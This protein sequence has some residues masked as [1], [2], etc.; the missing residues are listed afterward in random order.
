MT[1]KPKKPESYVPLFP[2]DF[3]DRPKTPAEMGARHGADVFKQV[4]QA[5]TNWELAEEEMKTLFMVLSEVNSPSAWLAVKRAY[6]SIISNSSRRTAIESVAE[7]YCAEHWE[8]PVVKKP[9][10]DVIQNIGKASKRRDDVA[11]G[12]VVHHHQ[13]SSGVHTD[14]GAFLFPPDYN[15]ERTYAFLT[16]QPWYPGKDMWSESH[17]AKFRFTDKEI[18]EYA[19][20]FLTLKDAIWSLTTQLM[21]RD[22]VIPLIAAASRASEE[23]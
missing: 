18:E 20:K 11:H 9:F 8:N 22:G 4:G 13:I 1:A 3:W 12:K 5:L 15:T 10:D 16:Q 14:R 17:H 6:G 21:K 23:K 2:G 7:V 19:K